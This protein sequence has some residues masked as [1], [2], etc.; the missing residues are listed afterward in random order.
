METIT[1]AEGRRFAVYLKSN[2]TPNQPVEDTEFQTDLIV[3]KA[4][5]ESGLSDKSMIELILERRFARNLRGM[6]N[7]LTPEQT[8]LAAKSIAASSWLNR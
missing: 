7:N 3:A 5:K 8:E 6:F 4:Y 1:T 2:K